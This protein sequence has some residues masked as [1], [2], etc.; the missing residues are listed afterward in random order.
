MKFFKTLLN[1]VPRPLLI[2]AS[3]LA[4]PLLNIIYSGDRYTDP[5][6]QKSYKKFLPYGYDFQRPNVLAPGT[7][8]LE[9]HRLLWLYLKQET[10]FFT[11]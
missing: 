1:F 2:K 5:I 8:S 11:K 9:R 7:L 4:K 10:D 6:N 3:F